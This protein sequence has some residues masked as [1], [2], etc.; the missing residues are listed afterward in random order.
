MTVTWQFVDQPVTTPAILLDMN[1]KSDY[2]LV[3]L[4]ETFDISPPV[5]QKSVSRNNLTDGG[6]LTAASYPNRI[7][8]FDVAI[9]PVGGMSVSTKETLL[10]ELTMELSKPDNLIKYQ[11]DVSSAPIFFK[12]IRSD[13]YVLKNR[14]GSRKFWNVHCEVEAQP[15]GIGLRQNV[16]S[17]AVITNNPASGTNPARIDLTGIKGDSPA[18]AFINLG[19]AFGATSYF[20]ISQRTRDTT[21]TPFVQAESGTLGTDATLP[22]NDAAF[23]GSGSN[24]VRVGFTTATLATRVTVTIPT[25]SKGTYR[26][27]ARVR[28]NTATTTYQIQT[29]LGGVSGPLT[30]FTLAS[31]A[32][33]VLDLGLFDFPYPAPTPPSFGHSGLTATS[34]P[35]QTMGIQAARTTGTGTLDIDYLY[36]MPA[37]ERLLTVQGVNALG[38]IIID[39]PMNKSYGMTQASDPF[40]ATRVPDSAGSLVTMF[41]GVPILV[42]GVTNRW[43]IMRAKNHVITNTYQLSVDYW[44][45]YRVVALP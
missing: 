13:S 4:D 22:G 28:N 45:Q 38:R 41:G 37:D 18:P 21:I 6:F 26:V 9:G 25:T 7:L 30:E 10:N 27:F 42:P 32:I 1:D 43:F 16:L 29:D 31:A 11:A 44:P 19:S 17:S 5:L 12:T 24:Y 33:S 14:G 39:G 36:F 20:I 15:F 40:G 3:N 35:A 2:A 23:S 8:Q 34:Y